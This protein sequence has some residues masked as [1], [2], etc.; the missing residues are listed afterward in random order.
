LPKLF[1]IG[2]YIV[3]FWSNEV[4][5]PIHVHV[6]IVDPSQNATKIWLIKNGDCIIAH[7][8]SRIPESDL[9]ELLKVIQD[10]FFLICHEWK[11]YFNEDIIE[12]YK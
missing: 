2:Q 6:G 4:N 9:N 8:R 1:K 11:R 3:F 5:E 10:S 7:N 12:F